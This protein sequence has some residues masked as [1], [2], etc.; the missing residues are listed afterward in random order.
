MDEFETL[1]N[2]ISS[3]RA[4]QSPGPEPTN[5]EKFLE[6]ILR[7]KHPPYCEL[8][9]NGEAFHIVLQLH[10]QKAPQIAP[11]LSQDSQVYRRE[12]Y[13]RFRKVSP[14]HQPMMH[15][16]VTVKNWL[17]ITAEVTVKPEAA[18]IFRLGTAQLNEFQNS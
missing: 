3:R 8:I 6:A 14:A 7:G 5:Y 1:L 18:G 15:I 10:F 2:E 11:M 4:Q 13:N 16:R 12:A 9:W 17:P